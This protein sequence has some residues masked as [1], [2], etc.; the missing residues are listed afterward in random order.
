MMARETALRILRKHR[1]ELQGQ[2]VRRAAVFGSVAR[3]KARAAS[4]LD[5]LIEIEQ[6][7]K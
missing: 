2:G 5:V 7:D 4:D 1:A 3:G 6:P